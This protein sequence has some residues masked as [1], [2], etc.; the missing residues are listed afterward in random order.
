MTAV[1]A[2]VDAIQGLI[3]K[4]GPALIGRMLNDLS[5]FKD[6]TLGRIFDLKNELVLPK[7]TGSKGVRQLDTEITTPK[8]KGAWGKRTIVPRYGMKILRF[9]PND[10]LGTYFSEFVGVND[11]RIPFENFVMNEELKTQKAEI[12][13]N[14]YLSKYRTAAAYDPAKAD[15]AVGDV[16][17]FTDNTIYEAI[18]I[19]GAGESP[20]THPAKWKDVDALVMSDGP[21]TLIAEAITATELTPFAGGTFDET[22]GYDYAL[23]QWNT[24]PEAIKNTDGGMVQYCSFGAAADIITQSNTRFGSGT[25]IANNDIEEGVPFYLKGTNKRLLVIP[26]LWMGTSRRLI[27]TKRKNIFFGTDLLSDMNGIGKLIED[28]HGYTTVAKWVLNSQIADMEV[29]YVNNQA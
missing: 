27:M 13:D 23:E 2:N 17:K 9:V 11:K 6:P 16:M 25:H 19:P 3:K 20:T 8:S 7:Y 4:N 1:S 10:Y 5:F 29:V 15:Y 22:D 26:S 21:G 12:N 14:I 24:I 18:A 28:V